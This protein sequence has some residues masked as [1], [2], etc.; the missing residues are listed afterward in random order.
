M[1]DRLSALTVVLEAPTRADDAEALIAA[2]QQM[3]GVANVQAHVSDNLAEHIAK[4]RLREELW[5]AMRD[6]LMGMGT[7]P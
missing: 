5:T 6:L 4:S 3:R 7:E 1:T 2:I